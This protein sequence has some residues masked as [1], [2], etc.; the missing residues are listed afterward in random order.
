MTI[1]EPRWIVR[2]VRFIEDQPAKARA[3][4]KRCAAAMGAWDLLR[5][6]VLFEGQVGAS[7]RQTVRAKS[8]RTQRGAAEARSLQVKCANL[9]ARKREKEERRGAQYSLR[10]FRQLPHSVRVDAAPPEKV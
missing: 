3:A 1:G 4:R 6:P 5:T 8:L 2:E 9:G 7:Q 10:F